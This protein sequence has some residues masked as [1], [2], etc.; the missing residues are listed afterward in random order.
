VD[1]GTLLSV[2]EV[3]SDLHH[4]FELAALVVAKYQV[5]GGD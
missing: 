2:P 4:S 3:A 1:F 5:T